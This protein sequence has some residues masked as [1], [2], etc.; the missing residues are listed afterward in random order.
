MELAEAIRGRRSVARLTDPAPSDED[1]CQ[2]VGESAAGPDHG[3]LRPWR[4]V[5]VRGE[6][7]ESLGDVFA[8]DPQL[9][10]QESRARVRA[11]PLRAPLLLSIVFT[12]RD[13]PKVPRWEQLAA[14]T[15]VVCNLAL[16]LHAHGWGSMWRTGP[17]SRSAL[18]CDLLGVGAGEQLLGWL[19][20]GTP[21]LARTVRPRPC[22]DPR[23]KI[24]VL[25][26][27]GFIA[28]FRAVS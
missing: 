27:G 3:L 19:Y 16:L 25:L 5:L 8:A 20:V 28:G 4:I 22:V 11:K 14:T 18:V 26:P 15:A 9:A 12:P 1:I 23:S 7:R 10:D 21:E 24:H 2:L 17:Q 6:A 13:N